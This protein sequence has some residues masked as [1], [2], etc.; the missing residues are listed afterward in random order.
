MHLQTLVT[1]GI[2]ALISYLALYGYI[3]IKGIKSCFKNKETYL[4]LPVLGY[5]VHAF[6]AFSVIELAPIF[7]MALG[8]CYKKNEESV[9]YVDDKDL[10]IDFFKFDLSRKI[11]NKDIKWENKIY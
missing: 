6:F 7:Y 11:N 5:L 8:L 1:Q 10:I 3:S 9:N 4:I 2:F